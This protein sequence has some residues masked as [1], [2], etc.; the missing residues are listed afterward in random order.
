MDV[1]IRAMRTADLDRV[2]AIAESLAEAPQW[3]REAY[4]TA[5]SVETGL[6]RMVVVADIRT[7]I[8]GFAV[9]SMVATTAEL[10]SVAVAAESQRLGVGRALVGVLIQEAKAAGAEEMV[11]EVRTSNLAAVA[12]YQRAGFQGVGRRRNY[13]RDPVEDAL[14]LRLAMSQS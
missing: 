10:E 5:I 1:R 13:Y 3:A 9:A 14:I 7:E 6:R 12:L 2:L 4:Q 8:V 11:L